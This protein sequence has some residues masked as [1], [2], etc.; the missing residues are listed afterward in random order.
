MWLKS[1]TIENFRGIEKITVAFDKTANVI[2]G[3]NAVGKTT[4]LE[5]IRLTKAI[6]APRTPDEAQQ[7]LITLGAISP[8]TPQQINF[9]AMARDTSRALNISCV[10]SMTQ[11]ELQALDDLTHGIA[12]ALVRASLGN[13]S[14]SQS[15]VALVQYLSSPEGQVALENARKRIDD[16][17]P[18]FKG[19][20]LC[21]LHLTIDPLKGTISGADQLSQLIFSTLENRLPPNKALFSYFPADRAL[22]TGEVQIQLGGPDAAA[23]LISHN[24]QPQTKYHRLKPTIINSY[25]FRNSTETDI[26]TDFKKIFGNVLK[27]RELVGLEINKIGLLSI[28]IKDVDSGR[29]FDIDS[30]SSGEKG[31]ILTFLLI[32]KSLHN[33]GVIILDEP[34]LH[35]NPA[36]CKVLL[37][38]LIEEYLTPKNL[39]VI[40]CSHSP[41]ILGVAFERPDCSL[42]HL[43]SP[44]VISKIYPEDKHEVF[45]ALKRL[46]TT[47]SD[48]LFTRGSIFV[49]GTD[50]VDV[51]EIGFDH[52]VSKYK[53]TE[54]GGRG[55]VEREIGTLQEAEMRGEVETIK[56]FI[57]D[58]DN[59]PTELSSTSLVRVLQ[60]KKRCLENY[61][62]DDKIIYDLLHSRD[63]SGESI[64]KRG[65]VDAIF[66]E[67]AFKQLPELVA[68][69]VYDNF[70]YEN[71]GIRK[72][73]IRDKNFLETASIL[74]TRLSA[75]KT[76][77][78]HVHDVDWRTEFAA[79]CV[80]KQQELEATWNSEWR[81][82][83]DG[84]QFF[85][86]LHHSYKLKISPLKFKLKIVGEMKRIQADGW[87]L[88]EKLLSDAL[89]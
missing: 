4:I 27:N 39:Q 22:P 52:L 29:I 31:L 36:V 10:Y 50:D 5:A 7:A 26:E 51:L 59:A 78:E 12:Q 70:Q 83:A 55:N 23:Q 46:G 2:V 8:H 66:K 49:E 24:S 77:L 20:G 68:K 17:I 28:R 84:K 6:L 25:V 57:F 61:L 21:T 69:L 80:E 16:A 33:G 75:L 40:I 15:Q 89:K 38:F 72:R 42:L 62:I 18:T 86:D 87:V 85:K 32:S 37:P 47:T 73:E 74:Y 9:A 60:W 14:V 81:T 34:E 13:D 64:E 45:D 65:E 48:V 79:R 1:A 63:F 41:E 67:L 44:T 54:L 43:Q 19:S 82:L 58:L 11:E 88:I 30:M 56:C 76:Q 35:L 53:I 71:P 3:P